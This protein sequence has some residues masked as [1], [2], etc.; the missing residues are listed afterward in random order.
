M[1]DLN[2]T[3][4]DELSHEE[5]AARFPR[6]G[7][8]F[9]IWYF[10]AEDRPDEVSPKPWQVNDHDGESIDESGKVALE[11]NT[12]GEA[13]KFSKSLIK[14]AESAI[15]EARKR[16]KANRPPRCK[17]TDI[18]TNALLSASFEFTNS[19]EAFIWMA[20]AIVDAH[21]DD[22]SDKVKL[23]LN[24]L[25]KSTSDFGAI[26]VRFEEAQQEEVSHG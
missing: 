9:S 12:Y 14:E 3:S 8:P 23:L 22:A 5:K 10:V 2:F 16:I 20:E 4:I 1:A 24:G 7:E 21:N 13:V 6:N 25:R 26:V 11:F 19:V 18:T 15:Q 17:A